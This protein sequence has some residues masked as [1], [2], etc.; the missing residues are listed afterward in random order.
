MPCKN[1]LSYN[2]ICNFESYEH[3][4]KRL[5]LEIFKTLI[6]TIP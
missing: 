6:R 1:H 5:E 4:N 3:S 2:K